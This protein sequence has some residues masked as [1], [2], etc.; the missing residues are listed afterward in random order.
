MARSG[1]GQALFIFVCGPFGLGIYSAM[2]D[3]AGFRNGLPEPEGHLTSIFYS[4]TKKNGKKKTEK[5]KTQKHN[6]T[7]KRMRRKEEEREEG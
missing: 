4:F 1:L 3:L 7:K 2:T 6:N 5:K